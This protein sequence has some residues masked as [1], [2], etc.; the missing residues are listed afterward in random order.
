MDTTLVSGERCHASGI[1]ASR[2]V[3][4]TACLLAAGCVLGL[5]ESALP[6]IPLV[7]WLKP[8]LANVAVIVALLV[9]GG[10]TAAVV[11]IGRVVIV[12]FATGTLG[13]PV[14]AMAA[15]GAIASL[16]VM[17]GLARAGE[18]FS[19][20]GWSVAGAAAHV[21]AQFL[22]ASIVAGSWS[23]LRLAPLS[24]LFALPLG[25]FTGLLARA[26]VSR[27]RAV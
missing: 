12:A 24:V 25:A 10:S 20:V 3:T 13:S 8:G 4:T 6:G 5:V 22:V 1:S 16:L 23:L 17:L 11:S 14:T 15:A 26:V 9:A 7:P 18:M 21:S 2:R 27:L 19:P